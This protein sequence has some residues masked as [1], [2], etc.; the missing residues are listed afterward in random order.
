[1]PCNSDYMEPTTKEKQISEVLYFLQEVSGPPRPL[2]RNRYNHP[3]VPGVIRAHHEDRYVAAL[4]RFL[5]GA[6]VTKYSLELQIWWRD[7]KAADEVRRR[8]KQDEGRRRELREQ[9]R[10]KLTPEE[11]KA[12][13][14]E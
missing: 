11:R 4:C 6:D 5:E 3:D 7:H 9:A 14:L 12:V 2:P 10:T 1:M 13:G 8:A